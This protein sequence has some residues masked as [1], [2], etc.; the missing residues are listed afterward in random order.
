MI[1]LE[2]T[3]LAVVALA[4]S[5]TFVA[6]GEDDFDDEP[7]PPVGVE[8]TGVIQDRGVSISPNG[9]NARLGAGPILITISNQTDASR[10]ITL[11]GA[12]LETTVG[13]IQP[14]DTATIQKS[15]DPGRYEVRAG[16]LRATTTEIPAA[17]LTIGA[18]RR[19]SSNRVLL[20]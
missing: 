5:C 13:P 12:S 9:S 15:L 8:L 20:P 19:S 2:K 18:K 3:C 11:E 16:T 10:T 1:A 4:L 6:C 7:R 14:K 17:R